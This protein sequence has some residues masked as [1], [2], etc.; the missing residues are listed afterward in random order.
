MIYATAVVVVVFLPELFASSVQ[1][2]FVGPLALAFIFAVLA[3]LLV[4]M[5]ATPAACA[6]FLP[7]RYAPPEAAWLQRLKAW[8]RVLVQRV[9]AHL[10]V[11]M[12]VLVALAVV[13]IAGLPFLG[14][15]FMPDFREG[16]F[17]MQVS[18]SVTGTSLAEMLALGRRISAEVLALPYVKSI[19]QQVGRAE[20]GEDTWGPHRSEFH[21]ELKGDAAVDQEAVQEKLR[22]ILAHYPGI[23]SEVVTF[24]GDRISE[25]LSGETAQVAIKVFGDDLD[26]LDTAGMRLVAELARIKGIVDLQ[27]KRESGT[28]VIGLQLIPEAMAAL[29]LRAQDVLDTVEAAYAGARVGQTFAGTRTVNVTVLLPDS[30]RHRPAQLAQLMIASPVGPVPLGQVARVDVSQDRYTIEHDG[31]QRRIAVTFNV[32]GESLQSVVRQAQRAIATGAALPA[33]V[34]LEFTGAAAAELQTRN[35]L[36]LYSAVALALILMILFLAFHWR[37]NSYLVLANLPFSL[38][39][40]VLAIAVTG[41][42]ISL[43]SVV[44]LVTVF[45]VSARNSILQLAHYEHLVRVEGLE[46][47]PPLMLRGA[48][49][50]LIPILMTAAVTALGLAPLA[51]GLHRPGQEIEGPM[52]VTV[53]GGLLSSTLLNLVVLPALVERYVRVPARA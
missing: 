11:V 40:S 25:S 34:Y 22:D 7:R 49:E 19:E 50:R 27:F 14:G 37:R 10:K 39:G 9:S 44:G 47:N 5:T 20:L 53:L 48:N 28:P 4:A 6:L 12:A 32:R 13:A 2:R 52:A 29:G 43:G 24:L 45:G 51:F 17:V 38:I 33:G 35:E 23:E 31:G 42:G 36:L 1:G 3:S 30:W 16:H 21:V 46:W 41:V 8:Q 15:T 26:A 18:S